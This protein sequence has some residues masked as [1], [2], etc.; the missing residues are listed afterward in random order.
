MRITDHHLTSLAHLLRERVGFEVRPEGHALLRLALSDRLREGSEH[1]DVDGYLH[2][3]REQE[4]ELERLLPLVTIGKT[5]FFRDPGQ[6][7]A[8]RN[9]LPGLLAEARAQG[10]RL[11]IWSAGC[12]SG[13]EA[14]SIAMGLI[15]AGASP[16]DVELLATDLNP[17]AVVTATRGWYGPDRVESLSPERLARFFEPKSGG[18]EARPELR[19]MIDELR[20]HNLHAPDMPTPAAGAWD[21]VFCRNVLI[22]FDKTGIRSVV[23]RFHRHMRP[24]AWL[25]LGY[26][27]SLFKLFDGFQLVEESGSFLYRRPSAGW[28]QRPSAPADEPWVPLAAPLPASPPPARAEPRPIDPAADEKDDDTPPEQEEESA[29]TVLRDA[30]RLIERGY[31]EESALHL[32]LGADR[33]PT[34]LALLLTLANTY[35]LLRRHEEA[36]A[37][38]LRV[39]ENEPLSAE[40]RLFHG[41]FLFERSKYELARASLAKCIYLEPDFPLAHYMLGRCLERLGDVQG[42]RRSYRNAVQSAEQGNRDLVSFYPDLPRESGAIARSARMALASL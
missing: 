4:E 27:E 10:R 37:C 41:I 31:F 15:E 7:A 19:E 35:A 8:L 5:S 11:S 3:L 39:L 30:I 22:Y 21:V 1:D 29:E 24:G 16:D 36:E 32:R 34:D 20:V 12:A 14:Y 40:A 18:Y 26:S 28:E 23:E 13:E 17:Q 33:S 42:A 9:L 2:A 6:F 25:F 38:Y